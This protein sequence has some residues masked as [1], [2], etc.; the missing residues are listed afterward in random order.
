MSVSLTGTAALGPLPVIPTR[1]HR[2]DS[3]QVR[4]YCSVAQ[5]MAALRGQDLSI[6]RGP[7]GSLTDWQN[8]LLE[9]IIPEASQIVAQAMRTPMD[10]CRVIWFFD[11]PSGFELT[12]P[13][14]HIYDV[15]LAYMRV[16]P[17]LPFYAFQRI[18]NTD[19]SEFQRILG[20]EPGPQKPM[21]IPP[22]PIVAQYSPALIYTGVEDADLFVDTRSR[23]L[24]IPPR[25][26]VAGVGLPLAN[27]DF[28]PGILNIE[29]HFRCG[30]PPTKYVDGSPLQYDP[31][32]GQVYD[33][34]PGS[35][36]AR[37]APIPIDWS[38]GMP[39]GF[40]M[41]VARIVA[42]LV[43]RTKWRANS[44]GVS[45]ISVDGAS[46]S[47]GGGPFNGDL[48]AE[49]KSILDSLVGEYGVSIEI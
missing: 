37:F 11:G 44:Q 46:E 10:W 18:R 32:S 34:K 13:Y 20:V 5:V 9:F 30:F 42:N 7:D 39:A 12:L 14:R 17:S 8:E 35:G 1:E 21:F 4:P 3:W 19:G 29:V 27:F 24:R 43:L 38:S 23:T 25:V 47:Y 6:F 2:S 40:S 33:P 22:V 31:N 48:D 45:S 28:I 41:R 16:L 26:L 36:T 15:N 49:T